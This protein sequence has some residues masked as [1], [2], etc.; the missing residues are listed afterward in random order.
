MRQTRTWPSSEL[1]VAHASMLLPTQAVVA[2]YGPAYLSSAG[3]PFTIHPWPPMTKIAISVLLPHP[4]FLA[5]AGHRGRATQQH[6]HAHAAATSPPSG[7]MSLLAVPHHASQGTSMLELDRPTD[8]ISLSQY[9]ALTLTGAIFS[10]YGLVVTPVN[11][12]LTSVNVSIAPPQD[13]S[14][15]ASMPL[16]SQRLTRPSITCAMT[17]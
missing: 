17:G 14:P 16:P 8:K 6:R 7:G 12:P 1:F 3:G 13:R 10:R 9:S 2:P 11:Y 15:P 5:C 4:R